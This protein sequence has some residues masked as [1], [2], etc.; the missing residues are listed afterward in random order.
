MLLSFS[1]H[2][3]NFVPRNNFSFEIETNTLITSIQHIHVS[4][5]IFPEEQ[6]VVSYLSFPQIYIY[7]GFFLSCANLHMLRSLK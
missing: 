6:R 7:I 1:I 2:I 5:L 4:I 3:I